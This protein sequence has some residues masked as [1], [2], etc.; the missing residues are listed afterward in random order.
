M[1][2]ATGAE[3]YTSTTGVGHHSEATHVDQRDI[4][5]IGRFGFSDANRNGR[6]GRF[7]Q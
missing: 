2:L 7:P 6:P 1:H 4:S 5:H 3:C